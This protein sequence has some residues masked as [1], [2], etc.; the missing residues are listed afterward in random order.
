MPR[1]ARRRME[2]RLGLL[3][4]WLE[5]LLTAATVACMTPPNSLRISS[6]VASENRQ[7]HRLEAS[8]GEALRQHATVAVLGV[9]LEAQEADR[10]GLRQRFQFAKGFLSRF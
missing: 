1:P 6:L 8:V 9:P 10:L 7:I 5:L 4:L 3:K 2:S